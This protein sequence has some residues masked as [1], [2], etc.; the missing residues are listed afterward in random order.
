MADLQAP[1]PR[2]RYKPVCRIHQ[3]KYN[4]VL[5]PTNALAK[6][7]YI[8][9]IAGVV[10]HKYLG[11]KERFA[12]KFKARE[13][14]EPSSVRIPVGSRTESHERLGVKRPRSCMATFPN[15]KGLR[16]IQLVCKSGEDYSPSEGLPCGNDPNSLPSM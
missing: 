1:K 2:I 3:M 11:R 7:A 16:P 4:L 6:L 15:H 9:M 10:I 14:P 5:P 12:V 8:M 13:S